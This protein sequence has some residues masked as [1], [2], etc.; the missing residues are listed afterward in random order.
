[1]HET[2]IKRLEALTGP[3]REVDE[4]IA[5]ALGWTAVPWNFAGACGMTW[6]ASGG[7]VH[8]ECPRFTGSIDAARSIC[9]DVMVVYASEIGGDGLPYVELCTSTDTPVAVHNGIGKTLEIAWCIAALKAR[10]A[11]NAD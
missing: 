7:E 5:K 11:D 9:P 8:K 6:Y 4:E 1:M 10:E 3:S 2:L